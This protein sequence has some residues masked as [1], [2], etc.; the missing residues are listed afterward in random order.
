M[1]K[2][3][4]RLLYRKGVVMDYQMLERLLSEMRQTSNDLA[5]ARAEK[6]Y[7]LRFL[8]SKKAMLMSDAQYHGINTAVMQEAYAL[9]DNEYL[10]LLKGY[11]IAVERE[12]FL[13][14]QF[15]IIQSEIDM[16]RSI[17]ARQ[18]FEFEVY[19]CSQTHVDHEGERFHVKGK[20]IEKPSS[21]W[22]SF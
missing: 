9:R 11:K 1:S 17:S 21:C 20:K 19:S 15:K 22:G 18:R 13:Y 7:L 4:Q 14:Y 12:Q 2:F 8:P 16:R 3:E 5:K 10:E 6:E